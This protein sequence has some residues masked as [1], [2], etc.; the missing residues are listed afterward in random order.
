MELD[1]VGHGVLELLD[2]CQA[3]EF[4]PGTHRMEEETKLARAVREG[5]EQY[6][7]WALHRHTPPCD[8]TQGDQT[9]VE[10]TS[11]WHMEAQG[12]GTVDLDGD[13]TLP[14][15]LDALERARNAELRSR[16]EL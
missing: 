6:L 13:L 1:R 15:V 12:G 4:R 3:D 16:V 10:V 14:R 2:G 7:R 8:V 9:A 5:D 11:G